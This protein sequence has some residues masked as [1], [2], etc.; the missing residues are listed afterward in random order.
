V[1]PIF[2]LIQHGGGIE[3]AEMMRTFN[4]GIGFV[5]VIKEADAQG[6]IKRFK[7]LKER[8][9]L[10]GVVEKCASKGAGYVEFTD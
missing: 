6:V 1:P 7:G 5:L 3:P 2:G 10:I 4:C 8:P 9:Y